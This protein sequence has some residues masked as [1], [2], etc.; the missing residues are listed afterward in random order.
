[1][2][3]YRAVRVACRSCP[4]GKLV[5]RDFYVHRSAANR[6][7]RELIS[8]AED[9]WSQL[10]GSV[11]YDLIKFRDDGSAVSFL[12]YEDFDNEPHPALL[13]GV[14]VTLPSGKVT[15]RDWSS[16]DN[17]PILHRK[18][19]FVTENHPRWEE[20]AAFTEA[21]EAAGLL[22]RPPGN[23]RQWETLV[24]KSSWRRRT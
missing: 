6:L 9:A 24:R 2:S 22:D 18:E 16:S 19:L 11:D 12:A 23:R 7:P 13:R 10:N 15:Y 3:P 8:L 20:W 4:F 21:E 17:P 5:E 1:M 14:H